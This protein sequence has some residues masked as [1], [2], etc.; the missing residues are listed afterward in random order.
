MA[1]SL[2]PQGARE[3]GVLADRQAFLYG[4]VA[5][6]LLQ[7]LEGAH[8]DLAH[9]LAA[10][11]VFLREVLQRG[12]VVL[13]TALLQNMTLALVEVGHRGLQQRAALVDRKSTRLNSSH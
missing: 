3:K 6:R 4:G 11:A 13:Q 8:L 7:L 1:H 9:T 2:A 10:D 5:D 12:R